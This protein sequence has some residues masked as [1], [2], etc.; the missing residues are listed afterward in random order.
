MICVLFLQN[1]ASIIEE[2]FSY[3]DAPVERIAGA[4]VPMPYAANL[5]RMAVP[6]VQFL[7]QFW[8]DHLLHWHATCRGCSYSCLSLFKSTGAETILGV[9]FIH[10]ISSSID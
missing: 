3:L 6:Q 8:F 5:E 7:S 1:S 2:S 4:D 9:V 10:F